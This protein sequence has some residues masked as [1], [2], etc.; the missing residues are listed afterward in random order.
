MRGG[1]T[2]RRRQEGPAGKTPPAFGGTHGNLDAASDG[3][4]PEQEENMSRSDTSMRKSKS[5]PA[6]ELGTSGVR[7]VEAAELARIEGGRILVPFPSSTTQ[8]EI[9]N[10]NSTLA[11]FV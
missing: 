8:I 10:W 7:E 1:R 5:E 11:K 2:R 9:V 4:N 6:L 3:F